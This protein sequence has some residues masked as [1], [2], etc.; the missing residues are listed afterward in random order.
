MFA[1]HRRSGALELLLSTPMTGREI[2]RGQMLGLARNFCWPFVA[3]LAL[4]FAPVGVQLMSAIATGNWQ[5]IL[6]AFSGSLASGLYAVRFVIDLVALCYV[7]NGLALTLRRP[8]SAPTLT[9]LFV[10]ILPSMLSPCL[11]DIVA[12]IVFIAWGAS[13]TGQDL[14]ALLINQYQ[15]IYITRTQLRAG[16]AARPSL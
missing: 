3:F 5:E 11:L 13:K 6:V 7:G 12:D 15:P 10:L 4:L 1:D 16:F 2:V 8:Q 9:L 14:R